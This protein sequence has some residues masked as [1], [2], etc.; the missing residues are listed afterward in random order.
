MYSKIKGIDLEVLTGVDGTVN[1]HLCYKFHMFYL[2]LSAFE[3]W[4][5]NTVLE[6]VIFLKTISDLE[7]K[8]TPNMTIATLKSFILPWLICLLCIL[9]FTVHVCFTCLII[10]LYY[11]PCASEL[12]LTCFYFQSPLPLF[13]H[14][15][16]SLSWRQPQAV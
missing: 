1:V 9:Y 16:V 8:G 2:D 4:G 13:S 5:R 11:Q 6:F 7:N 3:F 10:S 15:S 14:F 12:L